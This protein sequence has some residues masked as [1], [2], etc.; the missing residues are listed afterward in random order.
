MADNADDFFENITEILIEFGA[1][2]AECELIVQNIR[3]E[4]GGMQVV[5]AD[6]E[7]YSVFS[8]FFKTIVFEIIV[9]TNLSH[10]VATQIMNE[11]RDMYRHNAIYI[12]HL[13][14][15][16]GLYK[17]I[18]R[19]YIEWQR[20]MCQKYKTSINTLHIALSHHKKMSIR[21]LT[22]RRLIFL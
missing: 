5:I 20:Q 18:Q 15:G 2:V 3:K 1:S 9:N 11:V 16:S 7:K 4:W 10:S 19:D 14:S 12:R 8:G 6:A 17:L 13:N 21:L 22:R